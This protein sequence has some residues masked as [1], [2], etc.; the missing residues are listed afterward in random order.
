M[1]FQ[2][3]VFWDLGSGGVFKPNHVI[4]VAST[5]FIEF[6]VMEFG[7]LAGLLSSSRRF[8]RVYQG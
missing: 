8:D 3:F 1:V 5:D 2:R 6:N 4:M 7:N